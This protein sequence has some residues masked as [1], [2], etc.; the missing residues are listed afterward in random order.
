MTDRREVAVTLSGALLARLRAEA[1][2]LGLPLE[3]LVAGLVADTLEP[4]DVG[5][6]PIPA[7]AA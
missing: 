6:R 1:E 7:R 5:T 2:A 3:Y 4:A